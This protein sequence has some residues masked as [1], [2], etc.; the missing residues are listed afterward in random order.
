[1]PPFVLT[2]LKLVL[3]LL[4]YF[5]VYRAVRTIAA[6]LYGRRERRAATPRTKP[7]RK[8]RGGSPGRVVLLTDKGGR[9]SQH[10]LNG[11]LTIGR[12]PD[13]DIRLDDTYASQ[14]HARISER[15]GTW[16]VEDLGSTNGTYLNRT[17]VTA[18]AHLA[19]GD[20]IRIGNTYLEVRR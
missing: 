17:K 11:T 20:R 18:P 7:V 15:N 5:F 3:L 8:A 12:A 6:D 4:L 16:M 19:P 1:M 10:K 2:I 14:Q 9:G 13:T